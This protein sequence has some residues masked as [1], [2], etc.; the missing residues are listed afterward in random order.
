M[1][2][3]AASVISSPFLVV[4]RKALRHEPVVSVTC[5]SL[6]HTPLHPKP[7]ALPSARQ[8]PSPPLMQPMVCSE[9]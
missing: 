3:P 8:A 6:G 1:G 7:P 4:R 9:D 2:D 5:G